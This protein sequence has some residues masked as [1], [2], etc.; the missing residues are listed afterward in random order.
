M[1]KK[2]LRELVLGLAGAV[3]LAF[4]FFQNIYSPLFALVLVT[5]FT[6]EL[7]DSHRAKNR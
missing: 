6:Y 3:Y 1:K 4:V 7:V 2:F 5:L